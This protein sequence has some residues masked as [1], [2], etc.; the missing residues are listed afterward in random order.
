MSACTDSW[1]SCRENQHVR[2]IRKTHRGNNG[3]FSC[4]SVSLSNKRILFDSASTFLR[5][6]QLQR[7][8]PASSTSECRS[9]FTDGAEERIS[10]RACSEIFTRQR[11]VAHAAATN[12]RPTTHA[13]RY[14]CWTILNLRPMMKLLPSVE[15]WPL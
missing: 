2:K 13:I 15:L 10:G 3:L 14:S 9:Q 12:K 6:L 11:R 5:L 7:S 4:V 1:K 8:L